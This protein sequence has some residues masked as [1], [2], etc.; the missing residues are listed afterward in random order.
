MPEDVAAR[1]NEAKAQGRRVIAVGTTSLRTLESAADRI[2]HV[3]AGRAIPACSSCRAT[4]SA[5]SMRS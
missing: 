5:S 3:E 2:G 4:S 1:I